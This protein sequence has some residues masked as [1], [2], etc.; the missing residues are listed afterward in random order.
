MPIPL[1]RYF[2]KFLLLSL[3]LMKTLGRLTLM[4]LM[5][6]AAPFLFLWKVALRRLVFVL[7]GLLL[8]AKISA[9]R[10]LPPMRRTFFAIFGHRYVV[11]AMVAIMASFV[12]T[13]NLQARDIDLGRASTQALMYDLLGVPDEYL[14]PDAND[15]NA[16]SQLNALLEGSATTSPLLAAMEPFSYDLSGVA[17]P[18][19]VAPEDASEE[20]DVIVIAKPSVH[21]VV[22]GDTVSGIAKKYGISVNTILWANGLTARS[23]LRLGQELT[24]L[25]VSGVLHKVARGETLGA[26]AKKYGTDV[27]KILAANRVS[28]PSA[29]QIGERL[30]I[31]DGRPPVTAA[32]KPR[33]ATPASTP[34]RLGDVRDVFRPP[35]EAPPSRTVDGVELVWPTVQKRINQYY[36]WRHTGIDINGTLKDAT[37][38]VDAGIVTFS[39]WNSSGYGNMVLIDHGNGMVTRYAHHSKMYVKVGDQVTKGQ[40]IGMVGSTGRST[41][42]HLHFEIYMNGKRVNPLEYYR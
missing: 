39:G 7:Y 16:E 19:Y 41:G 6:L 1:K 9:T 13:S 33:D 17:V 18:T 5:A 2:I 30:V 35:E 42:P 3:G 23:V 22:Q 4:L 11:H 26:I 8:R 40:T 21:V 34:T 37:Y 10:V 20:D 25:P 32:P 28:S 14:A 27:D 15:V 31:P 12:A 29:I 36:K 38:A 24:V